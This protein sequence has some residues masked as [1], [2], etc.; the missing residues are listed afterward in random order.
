MTGVG[1]SAGATAKILEVLK[2]LP[3]WLLIAL[4]GAE[5]LLLFVPTIAT[6]APAGARPWVVLMGVV[7]GA[8]AATRALGL[9]MQWWPSWRA[10]V[11]ARRR[12]AAVVSH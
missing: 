4:A 5:G 9:L 3:R 8:L 6:A 7:S 2:D 10:S 12:F 11:A 1:E